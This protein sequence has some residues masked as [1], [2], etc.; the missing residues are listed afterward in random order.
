[1]LVTE[2][3]DWELELN[4]SALRKLNGAASQKH[5]AERRPTEAL[6]VGVYQ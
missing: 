5:T 4:K 1:M 6:L 3:D 2:K